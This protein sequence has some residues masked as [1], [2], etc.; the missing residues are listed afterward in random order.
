MT[1]ECDSQVSERR[2]VV[3][4]GASSGIGAA[5]T[6]ALAADGFSLH[7]CSRRQ[8]KLSEVT[9]DNS[10]ADGFPC[11]VA[12]EDQVRA[13]AEHVRSKASQIDVL[14]NCA[15]IFGAVGPAVMTESD[16]WFEAIKV[17]LL[18][19]YLMAKHIV[20][21][22]KSHQ[23]ARIV[24]FSGGGAFSV[25]AN[26]SSYA[27]SKA[28]VARLTENLA[29]E[30][31]DVGISVNAVA[32][33]FVATEIHQRTLKAGPTLAGDEHYEN[34]VSL[35]REGSVPMEL[36]VDCVRFLLSER[37]QEL[38]GKTLSASFDPWKT[39][40]FVESIR[41]INQ[42]DLY[43]QRRINLANLPEDSPLRAKL[44]RSGG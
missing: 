40:E 42:S 1:S 13:F 12:K 19:T 5:L 32:P 34:T 7:V 30:L 37:A 21:L 20:P 8:D 16:E 22:M 44:D 4:T 6:Q 27:V 33:G 11:D 43:S 17:N 18:G 26:Y 36:P 35:I 38:T 9:K 23:G 10:I 24:N 31:A 29:V 28:G 2:H 41:E 25:F 14:I 15:G 3:I 39:E